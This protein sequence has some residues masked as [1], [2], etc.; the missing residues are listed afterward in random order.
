MSKNIAVAGGSGAV[1]KTIVEALLAY[2]RHKVYVF[3]RSVSTS[4]DGHLLSSNVKWYRWSDAWAYQDRPSQGAESFLKVDYANVE[5]TSKALQEAEVD[6]IISAISM[7]SP[8]A[9]EA[10]KNLVRAADRSVCTRRFVVSG[11]DM[12]HLRE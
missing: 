4:R 6:T 11:F 1:G 7:G 8:E 12:L 10:Q 2:G 9:S 3:S 5:A